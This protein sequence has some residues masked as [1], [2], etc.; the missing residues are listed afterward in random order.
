M[1]KQ[2]LRVVYN[3]PEDRPHIDE[4]LDKAVEKTLAKFG[5][6][7]WASGCDL[8]APFERDLAF[9]RPMPEKVEG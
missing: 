2:R 4:A 5:Y 3:G 6:E 1:P 8:V 9:E 7:R